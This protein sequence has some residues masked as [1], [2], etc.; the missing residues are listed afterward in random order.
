MDACFGG[1]HDAFFFVYFV[2]LVAV[3][4]A[5]HRGEFVVG[6]GGFGEAAADDEGRAG[7]VHQDGIHLVHDAIGVASLDF[8]LRAEHHVVSEVVKA[9]LVVG[10]VGDVAGVLGAFVLVIAVAGHHQTHA[11]TEPFVDCAHPVGVTG[12]EVVVDGN[13]MDAFAGEPVEIHRQG[14]DERFAFAC[15]HLGHPAEVKGRPAHDLHIVMPLADH[16][17]GGFSDDR[18]SFHEHVFHFLAVV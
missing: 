5:H 13:D 16:P 11:E 14:G 7:F 4:A 2:V 3:E 10:A 17:A 1:H 9:E 12:G 15:L 18:E 6:L 8:V